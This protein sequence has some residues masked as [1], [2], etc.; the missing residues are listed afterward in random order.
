MSNL[1]NLQNPENLGDTENTSLVPSKPAAVTPFKLLDCE[2][3]GLAKLT[4]KEPFVITCK[5]TT[6]KGW[7]G[8]KD[9]LTAIGLYQL[10]YSYTGYNFQKVVFPQKNKILNN[11]NFLG[12]ILYDETTTSAANSLFLLQIKAN[13]LNE[14]KITPPVYA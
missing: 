3:K 12:V 2:P 11:K 1:E 5:P 9:I 8:F 13:L 6:V 7:D 14:F 4:G 10:N